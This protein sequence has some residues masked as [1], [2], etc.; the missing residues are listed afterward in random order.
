MNVG[1]QFE[2]HYKRV[3]FC[4]FFFGI[5]PLLIP[6]VSDYK[7]FMQQKDDNDTG[8]WSKKARLPSAEDCVLD[9]FQLLSYLKNVMDTSD[10]FNSCGIQCSKK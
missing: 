1:G 7:L 6:G 10:K 9:A 8:Y 2:V 4:C 5:E 3:F